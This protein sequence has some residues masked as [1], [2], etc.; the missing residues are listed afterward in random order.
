M[1]STTFVLV[2][3]MRGEGMG[4]KQGLDY[5]R[6]KRAIICPNEGF[7]KELKRFELYVKKMPKNDR[8]KGHDRMSQSEQLN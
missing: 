4:F 6:S 8:E 1:Q 7:Q 3:L 2:Y 5:V